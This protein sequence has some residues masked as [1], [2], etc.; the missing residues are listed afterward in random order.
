MGYIGKDYHFAKGRLKSS[1]K[2]KWL[3]PFWNNA[4]LRSPSLKRYSANAYSLQVH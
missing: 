3:G 4:N 1:V 2:K